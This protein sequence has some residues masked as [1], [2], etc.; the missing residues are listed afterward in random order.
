MTSVAARLKGPFYSGWT[1]L[2]MSQSEHGFPHAS[3]RAH[4][5]TA[6]RRQAVIA[7]L[8]AFAMATG[9]VTLKD[10]DATQQHGA[11]LSPR[12][13]ADNLAIGS[14]DLVAVRC[15]TVAARRV[16]SIGGVGFLMTTV[17]T[18]QLQRG[19]LPLSSSGVNGIAFSPD[20]K[21]LVSAYGDGTVRM[22]D[23]ATGKMNG[24]V[25]GVGSSGQ[26]RIQGVA[27]SPDGKLLAGADSDGSVE[28]W[29]P[30]TGQHVGSPLEAG[31]SVNEVAFSPDGKLLAS[32]D[33]N[34]SVHLWNTPTSQ[35][36]GLDS[37]DWLIIVACSAAFLAS[38]SA[39][40]VTGGALG[41]IRWWKFQQED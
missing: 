7:A 11:V 15:Q 17:L 5:G 32:A 9:I 10:A 28:L 35:S 31:S 20:G 37:G 34:G 25:L 21:L 3:G 22:W 33:A 2:G 19:V 1:E 41:R 14:T 39:V 6:H 18:R 16:F 24:P 12:L 8:F 27:F 23:L 30:V 26:G 40:L 4:R 13:A 29:N 36:G 38:I